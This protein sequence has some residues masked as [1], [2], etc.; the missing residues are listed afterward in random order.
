MSVLQ[1]LYKRVGISVS[2][3]EVKD[4]TKCH[5]AVGPATQET[6]GDWLP[7]PVI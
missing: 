1:G 5:T 4:W 3:G 7:E 6:G 2:K